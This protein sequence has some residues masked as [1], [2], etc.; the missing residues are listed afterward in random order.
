MDGLVFIPRGATETSLNHR[1]VAIT[2]NPSIHFPNE[3]LCPV[4]LPDPHDYYSVSIQNSKDGQV[5]GCIGIMNA[6]HHGSGE[7]TVPL[8]NCSLHCRVLIEYVAYQLI[9]DSL[10]FVSRRTGLELN[11][12][13][14]E[15]DLEHHRQIAVKASH[16]KSQ[17]LANMRY[18]VAFTK[19]LTY[20]F[21]P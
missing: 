12:I 17:F 20:L 19:W 8:R 16:A 6:K 3:P 15:E 5:L 10:K 4:I 7:L 2:S 1:I 14:I 13:K 21:K 11:R 9:M 18:S